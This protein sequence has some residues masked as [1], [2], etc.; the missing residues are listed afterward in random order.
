MEGGWGLDGWMD[1]LVGVGRVGCVG[2]G[3]TMPPP[4]ALPLLCHTAPAS[5]PT[6]ET[7]IHPSTHTCNTHKPHK[8]PLRRRT[9][10]RRSGCWRRAS[11][12]AS[13]SSTP[14]TRCAR[15]RVV[16]AFT[17]NMFNVMLWYASCLYQPSIHQPI[18]QQPSPPQQELQSRKAEM[19]ACSSSNIVLPTPPGGSAKDIQVRVRLSTG[20]LITSILQFKTHPDHPSMIYTLSHTS[21]RRGIP[22]PARL[23][24]SS[25]SSSSSTIIGREGGERWWGQHQREGSS[26]SSSSGACGRGGG[27]SEPAG[28]CAL[29]GGG[30]IDKR[31]GD[32]KKAKSSHGVDAAT[33]PPNRNIT[34]TTA[35][36]PATDPLKHMHTN[37]STN[38]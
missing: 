23:R 14:C 1:A 21:G 18:N 25:S 30:S 31:Q 6:R 37:Q 10:R 35:P 20:V 27:R 33:P 15:V 5:P 32:Q 34:P 19:D 17:L 9:R 26:S 7:P 16:V 29:S 22:G 8:F 4:T 12:S 24:R 36:F 11:P 3:K 38:R 2:D 28:V 13:W